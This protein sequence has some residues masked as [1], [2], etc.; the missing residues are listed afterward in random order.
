M[1]AQARAISRL[2]R[3]SASTREEDGPDPI[4]VF[5][6]QQVRNIRKALKISQTELASAIGVTFQQVQKYERGANRISASKL[7]ATAAFLGRPVA[8]FFPDSGL[9][10][11]SAATPALPAEE[12]HE[13][14]DLFARISAVS[15]RQS[16]RN[17][18]LSMAAD[19]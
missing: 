17:L 11:F 14:I 19:T 5:V 4:D 15:T 13:L 7:Y 6:G 12:A 8:H 10:G 3:K 1:V 9:V 16:L 18:L 2:G